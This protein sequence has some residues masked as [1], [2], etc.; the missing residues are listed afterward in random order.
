MRVLTSN[1][2]T[3]SS[4]AKTPARVK[5]S[6][7]QYFN[8][9]NGDF[10]AGSNERINYIA[11]FCVG[12]TGECSAR[13]I[14]GVL[15]ELEQILNENAYKKQGTKIGEP[16][17]IRLYF[18]RK[19]AREEE[20]PRKKTELIFCILAIAKIAEYLELLKETF[21]ESL[22]SARKNEDVISFVNRR[23]FSS[24]THLST[25]HDLYDRKQV[26]ELNEIFELF[27]LVMQIESC[28]N[29]L[30]HVPT[31]KELRKARAN[32]TKGLEI[33][34]KIAGKQR[35]EAAHQNDGIIREIISDLHRK[36]DLEGRK[37]ESV[38]KYLKERHVNTNSDNVMKQKIRKFRREIL[39]T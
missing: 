18:T 10:S 25:Y 2:L 15:E 38:L 26:Q 28:F 30:N 34:R 20:W 32:Y 12:K 16:D 6:V 4:L 22:W 5:K 8:E 13:E 39:A 11:W 1:F 7:A 27:E 36:G 17:I 19:N 21:F 29:Y 37:T 9:F 35:T 14:Q 33:G 3:P 31:E 24:P 23:T